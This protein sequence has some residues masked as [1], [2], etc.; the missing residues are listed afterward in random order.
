MVFLLLCFVPASLLSVGCSGRRARAKDQDQG[1]VAEYPHYPVQQ[2]QKAF[3]LTSGTENTV[4]YRTGT[5]LLLNPAL[6]PK[7]LANLMEVDKSIR[8]ARAAAVHYAANAE[9]AKRQY[10]KKIEDTQNEI[11]VERQRQTQ[12]VSREQRLAH[13]ADWF[14]AEMKNHAP[15]ASLERIMDTFNGYCEAKIWQLAA[16][17]YFA[18]KRYLTR[19]TPLGFCENYYKEKGFFSRTAPSCMDAPT[20]EGK[21]YVQCLWEEGVLKTAIFNRYFLNK[22]EQFTALLSDAKREDFRLTCAI[23]QVYAS[24]PEVWTIY[25]HGNRWIPPLLYSRALR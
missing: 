16:Q 12:K 19:P 22:K 7:D 6:N 21:S 2:D 14:A 17:P 23:P 24:R 18:S 3:T 15:A 25:P 10:L 4:T 20:P 9:E 13:A 5:M 11:K 8:L 1:Q